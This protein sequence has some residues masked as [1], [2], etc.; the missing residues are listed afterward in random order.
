MAWPET[1]GPGREGTSLPVERDRRWPRRPAGPLVRGRQGCGLAAMAAVG[2]QLGS[3]MKAARIG[4]DSD[5]RVAARM[6]TGMLQPWG[7]AWMSGQV[8][9]GDN[10]EISMLAR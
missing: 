1:S 5:A 9:E 3:A 8:P 4:Q 7:W 6:S 10:L 2:I